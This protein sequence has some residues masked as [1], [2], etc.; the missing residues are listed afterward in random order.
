MN[1]FVDVLRLTAIVKLF[2]ALL[3]D[4]VVAI[5]DRNEKGLI[6]LMHHPT[7]MSPGTGN[8]YHNVA[9]QMHSYLN[10]QRQYNA[11]PFQGQ[12]G[13]GSGRIAAQVFQYGAQRIG[14]N[15]MMV[16]QLGGV[17]RNIMRNVLS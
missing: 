7:G 12:F 9:A 4:L 3:F 2:S 8:H 6:D 11:S 17:A 5:I 16:N 14:A 1:H 15:P 10:N 13:G